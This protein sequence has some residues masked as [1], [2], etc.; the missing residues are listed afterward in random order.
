M[1]FVEDF[2]ESTKEYFNPLRHEEFCKNF[3]NRAKYLEEIY[4]KP[5]WN[6]NSPMMKAVAKEGDIKKI[7]E[8]RVK[9]HKSKLEQ[10]RLREAE[11]NKKFEK[12]SKKEL[13]KHLKEVL[14]SDTHVK[15]YYGMK[16]ELAIIEAIEETIMLNDPKP[17]MEKGYSKEKAKKV[18][19][20]PNYYLNKNR[21]K[22]NK[23][24]AVISEVEKLVKQRL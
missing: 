7:R 20:N 14:G 11:Q 24:R 8:D 22:K 18:L 2:A 5:V 4:G 6:K 9:E 1:L 16:E 3:P 10:S 12:L 15:A 17:L 21:E 23:Y 19:D 13:D